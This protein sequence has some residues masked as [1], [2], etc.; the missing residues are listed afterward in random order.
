M[1]L[2]DST[3]PNPLNPPKGGLHLPDP[4]QPASPPASPQ[5]YQ[6]TKPMIYATV[7][8]AHPLTQHHHS[9]RRRFFR[10]FLV[11]ILA[12]ALIE[13]LVRSVPEFSYWNSR[14]GDELALWTD[15]F[16]IRKGVDHHHC[17]T[18][19]QEV[20]SGSPFFPLHATTTF[21]V[22][23]DLD[24]ML[25]L[26][27]GPAGGIFTV[28]SSDE[29][30]DAA[31]VD[32][33]VSYFREEF[34]DRA[35]VCRIER[36]ESTA[37]VGIFAPKWDTRSPS[38]EQRLDF[39][40]VVTLPA[41]SRTKPLEIKNFEAD[42]PLFG[43]SAEHLQD[44][45]TFAN[46]TL[47]SSEM[48]I[49][50]QL[51]VTENA[52]LKTSNGP[53]SGT[54]YSPDLRLITA[55]APISGTFNAT[56]SLHL[57]T[58]NAAIH[59][60][61]GLTNDGDHSTDAVLKTSNGPIRS[62][63]SLLRDKECSSGGIYSI[64]TTTSNAALGVDF[65]TAPVN[66]TLSLDSKTSNAPATVSLHPTYEGRFDLLSSLFTPVLEKSSADDP[67]GRGRE[68]TIESHSSRGVLSG[69]V[70]WAATRPLP[71][72]TV[73][74]ISPVLLFTKDEYSN[75]GRHTILDHYTFKWKDGRMALALGLGSLLNHSEFPNTS[76][77]INHSSDSITYTTSRQIAAD[78]ELCIFYG[79]NLWFQSADIPGNISPPPFD[80][81]DEDDEWGGLSTIDV[82]TEH[83]DIAMRN[84]NPFSQGDPSQIIP[85]ETL[86]FDRF[87]PPP[88]EETLESIQTMLAWVVDIA[89]PRHT[90]TMLK[91]LKHNKLEEE[92]GHLK[93]VRKQGGTSTMLLVTALP[94]ANL[95]S[96]PPFPQL[97]E[98]LP[99][100]L[101][102]GTPYAISVPSS[103]A[104]TP[105]S[106]QLKNSLWP[107]IFAP[108]RKDVG[109]EWTR[110]KAAWAWEAVHYVMREASKIKRNGEVPIVSY[111]PSPYDSGSASE[112]SI[113]FASHDTRISA[114]HPLR[115][116]V[117]NVVRKIADYRNT[118]LNDSITESSSDDNRQNGSHYLLTSLTLFTSHEPC[119]MCSMALLHSRVKEVV[120]IRAMGK[121]GGC[122]GIACLPILKGVNHRF[123]ILRWKADLVDDKDG[124]LVV[125]D[126]VDA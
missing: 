102:L 85:E 57:I 56:K 93:R 9:T 23:Y 16:A 78:E 49:T 1:V 48:F 19:W 124:V 107:T 47:V 30:R 27:R 55:N 98:S 2:T 52:L 115:H 15:T 54:I 101:L 82:Y 38:R 60:D 46:I 37:G 53:I 105:I 120:Y 32:V 76:Y 110:G 94:P 70:Q 86:P 39:S 22:P 61:I 17:E 35:K 21:D 73:L 123:G 63:I 20:P 10:A 36:G 11:I 126:D 99:Q 69:R 34:R 106:H 58:S 5:F 116:S 28:V 74:E 7:P 122:G 24:T 31:R 67:S 26:A 112:L 80:E 13:M 71:A 104:L 65:P 121:T 87:K 83:N 89:D 29:I 75:Y 109:E 100:D 43:L 113:A 90:S 59:A 108:K 8:V 114:N 95:S 72:G 88:E 41:N 3:L 92:M 125:D 62:F 4:Y 118:P 18:E 68:R 119:V 50:A 66:S 96:D 25:F 14:H 42:M 84:H 64:K 77:T 40:V 51:L 117:M 97:L 91:W 81:D 79:N 103:V 6:S 33:V 44:S 45:V 12:W 111:V